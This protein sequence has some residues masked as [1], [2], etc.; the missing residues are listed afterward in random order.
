MKSTITYIKEALRIK[1][2]TKFSTGPN[3]KYFPKTKVELQHIIMDKFNEGNNYE[4]DL[5]D[6]DTSEITDMSGI[7]GGF[8]TKDIT[9]IKPDVSKWNTS[10]VT[11]MTG[12]FHNLA[13]FNCDIS[14]WDVSKVKS[15]KLMFW[16]CSEF[17]QDI[18]DWNVKSLKDINSMFM[19]A[20]S[21]NQNLDKWNLKIKS[22]KAKRGAFFEC[23][24]GKNYPKWYK[25][26]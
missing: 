9:K 6:I 8:S 1:S 20:S 26:D 15:M 4:M 10:N 2:G 22:A 12:L 23:G 17:N 19:Y 7:F 24:L 5:N 25:E 21:F 13:S 16:A 14:K 3:Y 11:D 18:S